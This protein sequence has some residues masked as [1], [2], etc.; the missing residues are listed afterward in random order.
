V[1]IR[2]VRVGTLPAECSVQY[3]WIMAEPQPLIERIAAN[4]GPFTVKELA[5]ILRV[6][7]R[8]AYNAIKDDGLP[9]IRIG[10]TIRL[11]P[12]HV[13]RWLRKRQVRS[14]R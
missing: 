9:V 6:S 14:V 4:K 13:A 7:V 5:A 10:R 2:A 11:D 1:R 3:S 8:S 12:V